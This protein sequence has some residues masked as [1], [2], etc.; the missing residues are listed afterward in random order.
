MRYPDA[1]GLTAQSR[2][3]R[4]QVRLQAAGMFAQDAD[5]GQVAR[6]LRVSVKSVY[7]WRRAWRAAAR[8]PSLADPNW[9]ICA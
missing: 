5:A 4:E 6:S 9:R 8:R 2:S 7:R 1:G 3:R